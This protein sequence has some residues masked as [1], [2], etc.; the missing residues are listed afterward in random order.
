MAKLAPLI[1]PAIVALSIVPLVYL[2]SNLLP[3]SADWMYIVMVIVL[4]LLVTLVLMKLTRHNAY[5]AFVVTLFLTVI[6]LNI[7]LMT[8][9]HLIQNSVLGYDPMAGARYYGI[10]NEYL[11]ILLGRSIALAGSFY[12]K[13]PQRGWLL[14][15]SLFFA[16]HSVLI[17]SPQL[18]AQSDGMITAPAAFLITLLMLGKSVSVPRLF[19]G[20]WLGCLWLQAALPCMI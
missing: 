6:T 15:M 14:V 1:K 18:G 3:W 2:F 13:Y 9:S 16:F 19:Y 8:G 10:G 11:G 4:T 17:A 12:Q 7:D 20:S 5:Q